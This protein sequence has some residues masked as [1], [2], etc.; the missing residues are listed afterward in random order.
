[1]KDLPSPPY[2]DYY[3]ETA[4]LIYKTVNNSAMVHICNI[5]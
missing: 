5:Y 4:M 3:T 2:K 1:M